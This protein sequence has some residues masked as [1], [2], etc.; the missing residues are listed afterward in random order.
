MTSPANG[1]EGSEAIP[2]LNE[3][4]KVNLVLSS[5]W[6][7][8]GIKCVADFFLDKDILDTFRV[9][10]GAAAAAP[11]LNEWHFI[12]FVEKVNCFFSFTLF[13]LPHCCQE[14]CA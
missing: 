13:L 9:Q 4:N 3:I 11:S 12:R 8:S 7:H 2:T 5:I 10:D 1:N 6:L 14:I